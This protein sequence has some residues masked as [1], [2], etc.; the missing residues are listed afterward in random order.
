MDDGEN[1]IGA[2]M[3]RTWSDVLDRVESHA[4][5]RALVVTGTERFWSTGLD[6][7]EIGALSDR[8][9]S[10]FMNDF[11]RLLGR[12]LT[13][14]F[15]TVAALNGH[16]IAGGALIALAHDYR[17][18][19]DD[20]GYLSL[21]SVDV[22]IPFTPGMSAL[23]T[24][25]LPQPTAHDLVVSCRQITGGEALELGVVTSLATESKVLE[26]A[27][28]LADFLGDKSPDTLATVKRRMYPEAV[29]MLTTTP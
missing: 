20:H 9:S 4:P 25:K 11:D 27:L 2:A 3:L 29:A 17:I 10:R 21:P 15:V 28:E 22:G 5:P 14:P 8:A 6:L 24:A 7:K 26:D 1:Q 13:A 19:R 23:I 18:M 16:A 12:I